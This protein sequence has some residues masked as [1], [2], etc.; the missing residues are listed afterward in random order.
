MFVTGLVFMCKLPFVV[1]HRLVNG[2]FELA[3]DATQFAG[4]AAV[5]VM[6]ILCTLLMAIP[7]FLLCAL[8]FS[9]FPEDCPVEVK[10][11]T[12]TEARLQLFDY[13]CENTKNFVD[14]LL[15]WIF[16][17]YFYFQA[18]TSFSNAAAKFVGDVAASA[19][20]I[21]VRSFDIL[22]DHFLGRNNVVH[23]LIKIIFDS[24]ASTNLVFQPLEND[25]ILGDRQL[26]LA[27]G[28]TS[29]GQITSSGE[30]VLP[31]QVIEET[32][33]SEELIS[34]G[35]FA[36]T[37]GGVTWEGEEC[38]LY[39]RL[40]NGRTKHLFTLPIERNCPILT[41][42]QALFI[43]DLQRMKLTEEP[44]RQLSSD[45]PDFEFSGS[46]A[47]LNKHVRSFEYFYKQGSFD[48]QLAFLQTFEA[49]TLAAVWNNS[50]DPTDYIQRLTALHNWREQMLYS[51]EQQPWRSLPFGQAAGRPP[52]PPKPRNAGENCATPRN[53]KVKF[54]DKVK[55]D[56][57]CSA[58]ATTE[59]DQLTPQ[60]DFGPSAC[61]ESPHDLV[62]RPLKSG[63]NPNASKAP[64]KKTDLNTKMKFY[65]STK[66]AWVIWG[67]VHFSSV[68]AFDGSE[69]CWVFHC[70][71]LVSKNPQK[72]KE[73]EIETA[74]ICYPMKVNDG[75]TACSALRHCLESLGIWS[76]DSKTKVNFFFESEEET[77]AM[78]VVFQDYLL[79]SHGS[80]H[81]S[82][83]YRHPAKEFAVKNLLLKIRLQLS[84]ASL[85][86]SAWSA[87]ARAISEQQC[88]KS[89]IN[90]NRPYPNNTFENGYNYKM[91]G[92]LCYAHVP[93]LNKKSVDDKQVP[94]ILLNCA[95]RNR[96]YIIHATEK[97]LGFRCT[98]VDFKQ[99]TFPTNTPTDTN[100][101]AFTQD[102]IDNLRIQKYMKVPFVQKLISKLPKLRPK[103]IT[104]KRCLRLARNG[105]A[106]NAE[107]DNTVKGHTCDNG[108]NYTS[109]NCFSN[110]EFAPD[111]KFFDEC[112][113]ANLISVIHKEVPVSTPQDSF[114]VR[115][116][117]DLPVSEHRTGFH[118]FV[119][120]ETRT[121]LNR[122]KTLEA[123]FEFQA[124]RDEVY[125]H[126]KI[127]AEEA[128]T[129]LFLAKDEIRESILLTAAEEHDKMNRS[130]VWTAPEDRWINETF[131][132]VIL[133]K[134][135]VENRINKHP[136]EL[137]EWLDAN[138]RELG[139]LI[140]RGVIK[141]VRTNDLKN[142]DKDSY[143]IIP[144][145][146]VYS[147]KNPNKEYPTGRKK[148]RLVACGNYQL[149]A[150]KQVEGIQ[151]GVYAGTTSTVVWRSLINIFTQGRQSVAA[152]DV[153]EAFTQTDEKSQATGGRNLKTFLRLP[154]QWKSKI[155]PTILVK[156]GCTVENYGSY[157]LQILKSIYGEAFAPKR[158]QETLKR[159]LQEFGFKE[160][161]LE[162]SLY[163]KV[164]DGKVTI[165][166]TYVDDI[167]VFSQNS[168]YMV[169]LMYDISRKLRCT[170]AEILCGAP[171]WMW[172]PISGKT[173][174]VQ[175]QIKEFFKPLQGTKRFG[176]ATKDEPLTY[177]SIDLY[178]EED[179]LVL[180]QSS[181]VDKSYNKM[182]EKGV[183][184]DQDVLKCGSLREDTFKHLYLFE[185]VP[186]N[187]LLTKQELSL[188]RIGVN[189]ISFYALS[190][191]IGLQA[192]LGQ[193]ARGQSAGRL[194]HLKALRLLIMYTHQHKNT[195][196][197]VECPSYMSK[198]CSILENL[199]IFTHG[200]YDSSMGQSG[201]LGTD[202]YARQGCILSV[203]ICRE[204]LPPVMGKSSLQTTVSLSTC[205][206]ELTACSW[207]A[208]QLIGLRNLLAEIFEGAKIHTPEMSGDNKAANLLASNQSSLRNHRH[209]QLPQ[210]WV[211]NLTKSG[212]LKIFDVATHLNPSD[213]LTKVLPHSK[214]VE[215]LALVYYKIV[216]PS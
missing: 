33:C 12:R 164:S 91:V 197:H 127:T 7:Q 137:T 93:A 185:D 90:T 102:E 169:K 72:P 126:P 50:T 189:T 101:W 213:I 36:R 208:K 66:G 63:A 37:C 112:P 2:C 158:W 184:T 157:I 113:L 132:M 28:G 196:L 188:L 64:Q 174:Q 203:G 115:S 170:P 89:S 97:D 42:D 134:K 22:D 195:V 110:P 144:S 65:R 54:D 23:N 51:D 163:Y 150:D 211:R 55:E 117:L 104:C 141:L 206:A 76:G 78:S 21:G 92:R 139:N 171:D 15:E 191:G 25:K 180:D 138:H 98:S 202:A 179:T 52:S 149:Q 198:E 29:K 121:D 46:V 146:V 177:V 166:S 128:A 41:P 124:L 38:K 210:I 193:V 70:S 85:P 183:F 61:A 3:V 1:V 116:S 129:Y 79:A 57:F 162:E 81:T 147:I 26:N 96:V 56:H 60:D 172:E 100:Y 31:A 16:T 135:E 30:I 199:Q 153:S 173:T 215:L 120:P 167:W 160:C 109:Y 47:L 5:V 73:D 214:F 35:R 186:S 207:C 74:E 88:S 114:P 204:R 145:L 11:L 105:T 212:Q 32:N 107:H 40:P 14:P 84:E 8:L 20:G 24:G 143:E 67:D 148:A 152:M 44:T 53:T 39:T 19:V 77:A 45:D 9:I 59:S 83:P 159:V 43:R 86:T 161:Q 187:P 119:E 123:A 103:N 17:K 190:I 94:A 140:D 75:T 6:F 122:F 69:Y 165:I 95:P 178:F 58:K 99:I 209:L 205:E 194:R 108:C 34:M 106:P 201:P 82:V 68:T 142:L 133:T 136:E 27:A 200:F 168:D 155:M 87:V 192:A 80:H 216:R 13:I 48:N 49:P 71:R 111:V 18:K 154:S 181:Y 131:S 175:K 4:K 130:S 176:V 151:T 182:R 62:F 156:A 10:L 118:R 125:N